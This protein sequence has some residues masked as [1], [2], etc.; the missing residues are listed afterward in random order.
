[1]C[2]CTCGVCAYVLC[3]CV[4]KQDRMTSN[5]RKMGFRLTREIE[6]KT[7]WDQEQQTEKQRDGGTEG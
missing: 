7:G 1:M 6:R 3:V 2:A 4:T 5:Y